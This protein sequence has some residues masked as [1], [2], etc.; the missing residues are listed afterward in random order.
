MWGS[1]LLVVALAVDAITF[2]AKTTVPEGG[3]PEIRFGSRVHG[4]LTVQVACGGERFAL[5]TDVQPDG[6]YVLPLPGLARGRHACS[7]TVRLDEPDGA[8]GEMPLHLDVAL[9]PPL[10]FAFDAS[11]LDAGRLTVRPSRPVKA[12]RLE[13]IGVGGVPLGGAEVDLSDPLQ[14]RFSWT[15]GEEVL[16]LRVEATDE[17][18]VAGFLELSPWSYQVPHEDVVFASGSDTLD[19]AEEPKLERCWSD[20]RAVLDKYGDVVKIQLFVAGFTDT[21]GDVAANDALSQ[22]RARTIARW[23]RERGFTGGIHYQGF[24]ERVLAVGTPDETDEAANRRA[25]YLLAAEVPP[26]SDALPA[27]RWTKLP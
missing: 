23:F 4:H 14:V 20:V 3:T 24:G 25:V 16:K 15:P 8:W 1:W 19:P 9:L 12:A 17:A 18:G 21:V 6:S 13:R 11:D 2:S 5:D 22:R 7:G 10:D 26:V 27:R